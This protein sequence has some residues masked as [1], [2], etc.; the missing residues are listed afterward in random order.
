MYKSHKTSVPSASGP[1]DQSDV[2]HS[3]VALHDDLPDP[4]T[5]HLATGKA[6]LDATGS[7]R[8]PSCVLGTYS[9]RE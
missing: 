4:A 3:R 5:T 6:S 2:I 7:V 1:A 9:F 8:P